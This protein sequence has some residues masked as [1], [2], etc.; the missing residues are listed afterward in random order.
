MRDVM[1]F[2][3]VR[4]VLDQS[5]PSYAA[6]HGLGPADV[7]AKVKEHLT[8]M[9]RQHRE[10]DPTIPYDPKRFRRGAPVGMSQAISLGIPSGYGG[11]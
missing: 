2:T 5:I 1:Y 9:S 3:S 4:Q 10:D 8:E 7:Y 6:E 11:S